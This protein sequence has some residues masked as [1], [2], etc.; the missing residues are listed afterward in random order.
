MAVPT[1]MIGEEVIQGLASKE[2]LERVIDKE[3]QKE[4]TNSFDG[5]QC[6]TDGYC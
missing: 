3:I 1:V 5:M 6:T 2:M 4:K